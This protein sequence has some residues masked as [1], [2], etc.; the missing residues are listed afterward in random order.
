MRIHR[1]SGGI[2]VVL[3]LATACG[4]SSTSNQRSSASPTPDQITQAYVASIRAYWAGLHVADDA[5]DGSDVDAKACLGEISP[6]SPSDLRVVE[7]EIC[8]AY[9]VATLA[10]HEKFLAKLEAIQAPAK[11]STDDRV[12][13]THVPMAISD[14]ETLVAACS[15]P[16]RQAIVDA[17]WAYA[18]V[19]IPDVTNALDDV[20]PSVTHLDPHA[21]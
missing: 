14:L 18:R 5:A 1:L 17:M 15:K 8:R 10:A 2:G 11:F 13:R 20:D 6:T 12:F 19:M 7:P 3:L 9:A 16:K 4:S 21:G